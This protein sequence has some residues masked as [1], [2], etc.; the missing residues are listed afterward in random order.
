MVKKMTAMSG[1]AAL[2]AIVSACS[3]ESA[4]ADPAAAPETAAQG[5]SA[6]FQ[7]IEPEVLAEGLDWSEGPVWIKGG[8][9]LLFSD[10]PQNVVY[11]WKSGEDIKP[12]L[13][14]SGYAG[15]PTDMFRE[16]GINGMVQVLGEQAILAADHGNRAVV[17]IDLATK[18]KTIL[19]SEF[20]GKT[21]SSPNDLA[22]ASDG[23]VYFS[24]PPYG[25]KGINDS[26]DREL[27]FNGVYRLS[28]EGE[29]TLLD[30]TLTFPNGVALS[31]DER[32][33]YVVVSDRAGYIWVAYDLGA[34]GTVSNK[35][36]FHD[37][38]KVAKDGAVGWPDGMCIAKTG[39]IV[40]TGPGGIYVFAS[41]DA[42]PVIIGLDTPASN[43]TFGEDGQTLFVTADARLLKFRTHL[44]GNGF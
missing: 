33:L 34:D 25:L 3:S 8:D 23:S 9:Y 41:E 17:R 13:D 40:S 26:P 32:T 4:T 27:D 2:V 38:M 19:V 18:D 10:V 16:S 21:L 31:P 12:F 43:C 39:E 36:I 28:P 7:S 6:Y 5:A 30:D 29:L 22:L 44:V 37:G 35:R 24:D 15:P 11:Q 42:E 20:D 14:P 1:W